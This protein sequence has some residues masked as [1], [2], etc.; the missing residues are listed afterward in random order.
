M[1]GKL[2]TQLCDL[3]GIEYPIILAGMGNGTSQATAPTPPKLVAAVSNAGGLGVMGNNYRT[4]EELDQ[5]I[6]EVKR[7]VGGKPFGVDLL[8][9]AT[10]AEVGARNVPEVHALLERDY[11]QHV[12]FVQELIREHK[13]PDAGLPDAPVM[14]PP[15]FRRQIEAVLDNKVPVFAAAIGEPPPWFL[16]QGH[17]N[18]TKFIGMCGAVRHAQR[19]VAAGVDILCAQG[20]E[21]GGHTGNIATFV[22]VPQIV[23]LVKPK[24]VI[25]AGGVG[26]GRQVAAALALGAQGVWVGTAF[27]VA[28]ES[29]IVTAHQEEI[30]SGRSEDF[31][32]SKYVSGKQQRGYRTPV[33]EAWEKSGLPSL[34]MPLQST[35]MAPFNEAA[36]RAGRWDLVNIPSGQVGGMLVKRRPAKEILA[37]MVDE[38]V[39]TIGQLQRNTR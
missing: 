30:L 6:R 24:P 33:K 12:A 11:P 8:L 13:L 15:F 27:L 16:E 34:P 3:L 25:A 28:E 2:R 35:V 17:A 37:D 4:P 18:G 36:R 26:S 22:L 1:R 32:L 19:Q 29:N 9:P 38:A 14:S 31:T 5:G 7:L 21:A 10:M 23:D 20:T 39:E